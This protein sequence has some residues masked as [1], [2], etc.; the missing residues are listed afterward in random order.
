MVNRSVAQGISRRQFL[1]IAGMTLAGSALAACVA[2]P[3]AAPAGGAA[4]TAAAGGLPFA[5]RELN[6]FSAQHHNENVK[7]LWVPI[8]EEKTGAK[9][10]WIE[11][12]GGD[13]DAKYAVFVASQ[14]SS[15]Y[16][17]YT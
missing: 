12:G 5:D 4:D 10:N 11:V 8:F 9:V 14:Y 1:T 2:A 16:T 15:V 13:V 7:G 6:I 17:M 3:V